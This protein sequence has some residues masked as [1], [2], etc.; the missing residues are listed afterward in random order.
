MKDSHKS[1]EPCVLSPTQAE[2]LTECLAAIRAQNGL[3][4]DQQ[5]VALMFHFAMHGYLA[6][7]NSNGGYW[8]GIDGTL[9]YLRNLAELEAIAV[10]IGISA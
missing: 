4:S 6:Y 9:T 2:D 3:P 1:L 7:P 5:A 8:V 10:K